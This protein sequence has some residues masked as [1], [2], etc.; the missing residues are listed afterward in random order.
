MTDVIGIS[1]LSELAERGFDD[2][3]SS[4]VVVDA[5]TDPGCTSTIEEIAREYYKNVF[6][7]DYVP[8]GLI[9]K[10]YST[11]RELVFVMTN[12]FNDEDLKSISRIYNENTNS[13]ATCYVYNDF[14]KDMNSC[15]DKSEDAEDTMTGINSKMDNLF[16]DLDKVE[17]D[18]RLNAYK[19]MIKKFVSDE[20]L[21][22]DEKVKLIS[23]I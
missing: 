4:I 11:G 10:V 18:E 23:F 12:H 21:S 20:D 16:A 14:I 5:D 7:T 1:E 17:K 13:N 6:D 8:A 3:D 19:R 22:D 15:S 9:Y 2:R